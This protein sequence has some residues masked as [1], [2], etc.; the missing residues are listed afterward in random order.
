[1][2]GNAA[3]VRWFRAGGENSAESPSTAAQLPFP[4]ANRYNQGTMRLKTPLTHLSLLVW[5][6]MALTGCSILHIQDSYEIVTLTPAQTNTPAPTVI[7]T[8][9]EGVGLTFLQ[10]WERQ[11]FEGMYSLLASRSQA[12][13]ER[14]AFVARY[15]EAMRTAQVVTVEDQPLAMRYE[16]NSAEMEAQ[17]IWHTAVVGDII[18]RQAI[19]FVYENNHWGIVWDESLI[20]PELAG[21][22]RLQL[23]TSSPSRGAIYDRSG[24]KALAFQG[25]AVVLGV[26]PNKLTDE[27]GFLAAVG[28]VLG[29]DPADLRALYAGSPPDWYI[30]LGVAAA[31]VVQANFNLLQPFVNT[32]LVTED[33]RGRQYADNLAPHLVG[34]TGPIPAG[35]QET[36]LAE[37]YAPDDRVGLAGL[38]RW[39]EPFLR[40]TRGGILS[41]VNP[42]GEQAAIVQEAERRRA[43]NVYTTFDADFQQAVQQALAEAITTHPVAQAG[44]IMVLDVNSGAIR[45]MATYP[46][47]NPTIFDEI[48]PNTA[49]DLSAILNDPRR[50]LLNRAAQGEYAPGSTFKLVTISAGLASGLYTPDTRY[51]C[52]G[53]WAGLGES[54]IKY[55][56]LPGG[57]GTITLVQAL[58]RSCNP[59]FYQVGLVVD[60]ADPFLLP[61]IARAYGLGSSTGIQ[62]GADSAG[63]IPDP[64]WKLQNLGE[65]WSA[66]DAVNMAIGQGFVLVTPLQLATLTAAI[67]NGG[68]LYQPSLISRIGEGEGAPEE[69]VT[70]VVTG[71]GPL[72]AEQLAAVQTGMRDVTSSPYGTATHIFRGLPVPTAGKTGTAQAP[73]PEALPHAW[74]TGYTPTEPYTAPDG[75]ALNGPE[76]AITVLIENAG[77][78]SAVAAP[79]FRRIV[80]LYFGLPLTPLPWP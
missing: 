71:Q 1:M 7:P 30:P 4:S 51:A 34:Y 9:A 61:K 12:L 29:Q 70:P 67:A 33:R 19:P 46:T 65:G 80:E 49:D 63:L 66:G 55:D 18:R 58:T 60:G 16:G 14:A 6:A 36:Y 13:V 28:A 73:D 37:G 22:Q 45:A 3:N 52:T 68:T 48:R 54:L 25:D 47:Y 20:L 17:V 74:F 24:A 44:A 75:R 15:A 79:I 77:E 59:Y 53:I 41:V 39:G 38:E 32:G 40:G 8:G 57:H 72:S 5:L 23:V 42:T 78:G 27:A 35:E 43:R 76:I 10:A 31:D 62:G 26:V 50:L 21:G 56:W 64:D 2:G 11:D 69:T